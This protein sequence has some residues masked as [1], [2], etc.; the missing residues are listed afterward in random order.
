MKE[1][2]VNTPVDK[3]EKQL[4]KE[5]DPENIKQIVELFNLNL[6]KKNIIRNAKLS[7]V[8]DKVVNQITERI[9]LEPESFSNEDL[10]KYHKT[11][12][13]T[14]I[15]TSMSSEDV[16]MPT[17]QINQQVNVDKMVFDSDSRK[18]ILSAVNEILNNG[19]INTFNLEE[20]NE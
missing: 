11:I 7:D 3:L 9:D 10:I 8:Q 12:Q 1:L 19:E 18:R 15:K 6:Q 13:E 5:T 2:K 14:L 16:K 20:S 17:I 4:L